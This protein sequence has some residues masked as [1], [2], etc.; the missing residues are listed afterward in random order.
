MH[1]DALFAVNIVEFHISSYPQI[2]TGLLKLNSFC[3]CFLNDMTLGMT[4]KFLLKSF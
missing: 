4:S 2:P 1:T 3:N